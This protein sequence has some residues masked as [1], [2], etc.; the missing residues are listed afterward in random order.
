MCSRLQKVGTGAMDD[1][2]WFPF[3]SRLWGRIVRVSWLFCD[4][5]AGLN[6]LSR[7]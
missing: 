6:R 1:L 5:P 7:L 2:C 4:A 3:F